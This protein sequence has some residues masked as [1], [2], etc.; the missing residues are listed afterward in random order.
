MSTSRALPAILA[1]IKLSH[2][3]FALPFAV[4]GLVL[5]T[6]GE[7]PSLA[8]SGKVLLAMI[9]ARSAAMG[10]NRL[11]D[12]RYDRTNPRTRGRALP[13][14]RIRPAAMI[15]FVAACSLAFMAVAGWLSTTC[16]LLSPAVLAVLFFYSLTKRFT[17]LAH[18]FVGLAL[19]LA[20]PAA[21]LAARGT[22]GD[23][24]ASV[25]WFALSVLLWV[26]GFDVIYACQDVEHDRREGLHALPARIGA[27]RALLVAR[28]LHVG[29]LG[30]LSLAVRSADLGTPSWIG[31]AL[32]AAL[33]VV[34]HALVSARDLSRV[35]AAFFTVNGVVSCAFSALVTADLLW[36]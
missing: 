27:E 9:L 7:V 34:E 26:A 10:F 2:S 24:V 32:V 25:L 12:Q 11:A 36:R 6:R 30:A 22:V 18:A 35:N 14:G 16:L 1:D 29:M 19:A 20:P 28:A 21:Y 5:G 3:V 33:L 31:V 23:D 13:S 8:L 4:I 15:A 17:P